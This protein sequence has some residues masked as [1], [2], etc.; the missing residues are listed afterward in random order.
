MKNLSIISVLFFLFLGS[1]IIFAQSQVQ[2]GKF[3]ANSSTANYTLDKNSGD[4]SVTIEV[5]FDKPFDKKPTVV[6]GVSMLDSDVKANVHYNLEATAVSRDG[7]TLKISTWGD[8]KLFG[9]GGSWVACS[10]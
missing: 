1:S 3:L 2:T 4:R 8:S 9:I 10:N 7:F 6:V 5:T